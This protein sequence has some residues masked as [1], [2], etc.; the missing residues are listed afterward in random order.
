MATLCGVAGAADLTFEKLGVPVSLRELGIV[1]VT[2]TAAGGHIAW[3][4]RKQ[5]AL[6]GIEVT[7]GKSF[8]LDFRKV[9]AVNLGA[10]VGP[11]GDLF[12]YVGNP[13]RFYKYTPA[14]E[15]VEL[16]IPTKTASYWMGG[17]KSRADV[18]YVGTYPE[19]I[20]VACDM[21]TG[22]VSSLGRVTDDKR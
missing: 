3:G 19:A 14:A 5:E 16:G 8:L 20:L 9:R 12:F 2:P 15:L 21:K 6:V 13:G 10:A 11:A 18:L 4:W 17:H 7:T 1:A 22:K